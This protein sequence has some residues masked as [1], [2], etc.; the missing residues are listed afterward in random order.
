MW[1]KAGEIWEYTPK[2]PESKWSAVGGAV[3]LFFVVVALVRGC[4]GEAAQGQT[5]DTPVANTEDAR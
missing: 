2:K 5:T 4:N 3:V 1:K